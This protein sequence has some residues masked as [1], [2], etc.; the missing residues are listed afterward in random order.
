MRVGHAPSQ[1]DLDELTGLEPIS[2]MIDRAVDRYLEE[3]RDLATKSP[4]VIVCI[5]SPK[6]LKRIDIQSGEAHRPPIAPKASG[7]ERAQKVQFHDL[8][9]AR[10]MSVGRPL[11]VSRPGTIC[12]DVQR[13]R[14]DGTAN[15]DMQDEA[16]RPG[17]SSALYTTKPVG[18][19]GGSFANQRIL[20]P[21][22]SASAFLKRKMV[23]AFKPA[24]RKCSTS[25][26]RESW[27]GADRRR[28]P[29]MTLRHIWIGTTPRNFWCGRCRSTGASIGHCQRG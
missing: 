9:K 11:Q 27:S 23:P 21:A 29:K 14:L 5:L 22:M 1:R 2:L 16:T 15:V 13:Y 8:L 19:R 24:L 25:A 10:G 20:P 17:I 18:H 3:A 4:D 7:E 6:L 26:A 28:S 12:G